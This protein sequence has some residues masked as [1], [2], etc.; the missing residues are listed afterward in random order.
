MR[1]LESS[2]VVVCVLSLFGHILI[3]FDIYVLLY[4]GKN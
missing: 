2:A 3:L 1:A 4:C